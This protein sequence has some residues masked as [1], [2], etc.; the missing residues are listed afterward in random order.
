MFNKCPFSTTLDSVRSHSQLNLGWPSEVTAL[1]LQ[2]KIQLLTLTTFS[3]TGLK[4]YIKREY[5]TA[6][7]MTLLETILSVQFL[8]SDTII[9]WHFV[10][11][12]LNKKRN[13]V[14]LSK[15]DYNY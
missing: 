1:L 5:V 15:S 8:W 10:I 11:I 6:L 4:K 13:T 2:N 12:W 9:L 14:L 7:L 3:A